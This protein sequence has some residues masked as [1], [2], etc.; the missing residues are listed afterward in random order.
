MINSLI[1]FLK[2]SWSVL[3]LL[4]VAEICLLSPIAVPLQHAERL[5]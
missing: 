3:N 5:V 4:H 2:Q 1:L